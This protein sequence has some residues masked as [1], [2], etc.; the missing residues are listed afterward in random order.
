MSLPSIE[1]ARG[2]SAKPMVGREG[3]PLGRITYIYLDRVTGQPTWA[4]VVT[5]RLRRG[6]PPAD[7][8]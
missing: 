5:E 3:D 4:V 2:W 1:T 8:R 7:R 6:P